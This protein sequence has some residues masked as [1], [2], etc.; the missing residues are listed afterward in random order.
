MKSRLL[1]IL[2]LVEL[3]CRLNFAISYTELFITCSFIQ[4]AKERN[5]KVIN[6]KEW[7]CPT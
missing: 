1:G 3:N 6:G 2:G 5:V 4:E 7:I